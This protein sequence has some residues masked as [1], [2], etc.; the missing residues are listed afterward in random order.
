MK[1]IVEFLA[2]IKQIEDFFDTSIEFEEIIKQIKEDYSEELL[3]MIPDSEVS[4]IIAENFAE[5]YREYLYIMHIED[6]T[7]TMKWF[8]LDNLAFNI[9]VTLEL[10]EM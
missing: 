10:L 1:K 6:T 5:E 3:D 7:D 4:A 8:I 9:K 2:Y